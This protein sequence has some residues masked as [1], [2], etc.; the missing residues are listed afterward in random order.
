MRKIVAAARC[1]PALWF[2]SSAAYDSTDFSINPFLML[3]LT[4]AFCREPLACAGEK[5]GEKGTGYFLIESSTDGVLEAVRAEN[6]PR[7]A[8]RLRLPRH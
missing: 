4:S 2:G 6:S 3:L 5:A 8:R 1:G 7:T